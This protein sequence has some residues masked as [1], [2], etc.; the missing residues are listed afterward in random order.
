MNSRSLLLAE[1]GMD[2]ETHRPFYG[3]PMSIR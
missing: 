3:R 1:T 2:E